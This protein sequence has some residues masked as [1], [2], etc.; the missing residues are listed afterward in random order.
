MVLDFGQWGEIIGVEILNLVFQAGKGC[1]GIISRSVP[2]KSEGL[3]YAY[4]EASD[5]FYLRFRTGSSFKQKSVQGS[6]FLDPD[7]T[8]TGLSAK[9]Q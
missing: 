1:L 5:S 3:R 7:G 4:D 9:W 6:V 8:I 2:T